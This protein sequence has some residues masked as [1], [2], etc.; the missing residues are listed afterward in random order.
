[1]GH[2]W[3]RNMKIGLAISV[4]YAGITCL[5]FPILLFQGYS[6]PYRPSF[7]PTYDFLI[8]LAG[9]GVYAVISIGVIVLI[10]VNFEKLELKLIEQGGDRYKLQAL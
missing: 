7:I 6:D 2:P 4:L 9:S 8:L 1:M 3:S 5:I 10:S